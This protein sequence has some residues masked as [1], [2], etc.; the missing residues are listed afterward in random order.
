MFTIN[1][2]TDEDDPKTWKGVKYCVWQKERGVG[3]AAD[4]AASTADAGTVH[5]Q[6]YVMFNSNRRL[7]GL[8]KINARAHWERRMGTHAQAEVRGRRWG[9]RHVC[10]DECLAA[11]AAAAAV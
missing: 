2:P 3:G 1:N 5:L 6:G 4:G 11:A 9:W 8:K 10:A 7:N